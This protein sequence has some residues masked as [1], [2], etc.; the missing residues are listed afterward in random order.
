MTTTTSDAATT[1]TQ[2]TRA[3]WAVTSV[4]AA[5]G[6]TIAS[7]AVRTPSLKLDHGLTAG[8]LGVVSALFGVAALV[9][10]QLTGGLAARLGSSWIVRSATVLL[11]LAL[12]GVGF[13]RDLVQLGAA[14]LLFGAM[15]GMVDVTMNAHAVAVER[16]MRR[17]IMNGCHAAWSIGA[18]AGSLA[19]GAAAQAGMSR[20]GHYLFVAAILVS[21]ALLI[22]RWLLPANA[23]RRAGP[24][25]ASARR[26]EWRSGWTRRLL[27]L[28]ALGATVLTC[29]AAVANWSGVL[30]HE[31]LGASLGVA[32]LG[33]IAFTACQTTGRL[34]GDRLFAR[35]PARVL[36]RMGAA[37]AA[38]VWPSWY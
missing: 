3:R 35:Y 11:P 31:T 5:N 22:G 29:E 9:T 28:G 1:T 12:L 15:N 18:V 30:L 6:V 2:S 32:S 36:V 13:A 10:M 33:Y 7:L 14:M 27:I 25:T 8:Q 37:I 23:D 21:V 19:G 24:V 4:F 34:A 20:A 17:P 38:A 26:R 16:T